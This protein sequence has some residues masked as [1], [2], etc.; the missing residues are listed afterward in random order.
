MN[1]VYGL[2]PVRAILEQNP[3]SIEKLLLSTGTGADELRTLAQRGEVPVESTQRRMLDELT[4]GGVHQG[5]A[6]L[7]AEPVHVGIEHFFAPRGVALDERMVVVADGI[8]DPRNF[9]AVIRSAHCFGAQGVIYPKDRAV[10]LTPVAMKASAGSFAHLPLCRVTN[11]SRALETLKGHGYWTLA[12]DPDAKDQPWQLDLRRPVALVVGGEGDGI[13][14]GVRG[15]CDMAMRIPM[16]GAS[17]SLNVA[18]SAAVAMYEV[19]RQRR[20]T[21]RT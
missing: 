13:R 4:E 7:V 15:H 11:V 10:G 12:L 21:V 18:S 3:A 20:D 17:D 16:S 5:V 1:V 6:A 2:N 9:G 8:V 14:A 19:I